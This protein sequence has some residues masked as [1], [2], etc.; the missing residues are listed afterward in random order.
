M[1]ARRPS[2]PPRIAVRLLA[3]AVTGLVAAC[4]TPATPPATIAPTA[5]PLPTP[6]ST[7]YALDTTAWYAGL[8]IHFDAASSVLDEGGGAVTV[9]LRLENPGP[10][11]ASL[12]VGVLLAA[13]GRAVEPIRETVIP[14]VPPGTSVGTALRFDV[15]GSF[16]VANAAIRI[17]RATEHIVIVPLVAGSQVL[18]TLEPVPLALAGKATAGTLTI[19]I[20]GGELRSD[21]PDW[22]L[23]LPRGSMS[24]AITY[25]ARYRGDFAGGFAFTGANLGLR[26]PDGTTV[27]ARADGHSQSVAVL[28]PGT[29][30]PNLFARFEVPVPA[31][32]QYTLVVRDGTSRASIPFT[33]AEAGPGG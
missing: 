29:A 7:T 15:D 19:A 13:G 33:I 9:D 16:D 14:D 11:L 8:I 22:G 27:G 2:V 31:A 25:T 30:V 10:E 6:V 21:L 17:G 24:L 1:I 5:T 26:L 12:S 20:T 23:E 3:L 28:V 4:A 18:T 32:G